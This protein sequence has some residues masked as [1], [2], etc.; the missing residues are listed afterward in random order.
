[1]EKDSDLPSYVV[2]QSR[3]GGK[4]RLSPSRAGVSWGPVNWLRAFMLTTCPPKGPA[5]SLTVGKPREG[6]NTA[7][8]LALHPSFRVYSTS[9]PA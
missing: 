5:P 4:A 8:L 1:M 7:P 2:G 3:E 6:F 9:F